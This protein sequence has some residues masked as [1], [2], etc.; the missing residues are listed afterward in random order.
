MDVRQDATVTAIERVL[1][2]VVNIATE[3][4][5]ERHDFYED[6]LRQFY[7]WR[8]ARPEK[9][10]SLGSG[11][12][13][14]EEGYL[15]TND[16]VVSRAS[17]IQVKLWDGREFDAEPIS[18]TPGSDV[19]LLKIKAKGKEKFTAIKFA[20]DDDLLLGETVL[21]LGNPYGLGGSVTR[22][23]LSAKSRRPMTDKEPLNAR[24]WLETD[25][26]INPG[27]SGGPLVNLRGE[28][29]GLNVAVYREAEG[30]G[31][32]FAI[33][34]KHVGAALARLFTPEAMNSLAFGAQVKPAGG[35]VMVTGVDPGGPAAAADLRVGDRIEQVNGR[36]PTSLVLFTQLI[37][38]SEKSSPRFDVKRGAERKTIIVQTVTF[39]EFIRVKLGLRLR[40]S[41]NPANAPNGLSISEL[42]KDGPADRARLQPGFVLTSVD[43]KAAA[44]LR[45]VAELLQARKPGESTQLS[46]VAPRQLGNGFIE[47]R[48]GT[49]DIP[50]R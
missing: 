47:F 50:V 5:I 25:A 40:P 18:S 17:R 15:L 10:I 48:Q 8:N 1:P 33:P 31:L 14:D 28:L 32:G 46:L 38:T 45:S 23:I 49:V 22:G 39:E 24:D 35:A 42:E 11:V 19:A 12:I 36:A 4:V 13:I 26:N 30:M 2:S 20:L 29:I 9:S 27:N 37:A 43:G 7:G 44:D 16:H 6:L 34:V 21:A 3:R 41:N